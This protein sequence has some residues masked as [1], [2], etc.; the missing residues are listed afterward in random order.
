MLNRLPAWMKTKWAL[1]GLSCAATLIL[2]ALIFLIF[3]K[4]AFATM[5]TNQGQAALEAKDYNKAT[6]KFSVALSLKKNREA[7]YLGYSDALIGNADYSA[8][9]EVLEKGIDRLGGAEELYLSK[10]QVLV[11]SGK[12]GDAVDFLDNIT[13]TYINKKIQASRPAD[14][15]YAPAQGKYSKS[16]EVTIDVR[17]DE[18]VYYTLNGEDPTVNSTVYKEPFT[19]KGSTVITAIAVSEDGLVSPRLTISYEI[20]NANEAIDFSD[21][22]IERMVR[23]ALNRPSGGLYAAQLLSVTDLYNDGINGSIRTLEDLVYLP[24]LQSLQINGELLIE[25]YTPLAG[26]PELTSLSISGCAL[27]DSDLTYISGLSNLNSLHIAD[28]QLTTLDPL[29]TLEN[30]EYLNVSGNA[31]AS[32]STLSQFPKLRYLFIAKNHLRELDGLSELPDLDV[33]DLSN[34]FISDLAPLKNLKA[35]SE[36]HLNGNTPKNIKKLAE[37]PELGILNISDCGLASLSVVNG[38]KNLHTLM[39]YDNEIASLST[40]TLKVREL[41]LA[42]NPL[43]DISPLKKQSKLEVLDL[44]GTSISDISSLAGSG[45]TY[46]NISKTSVTDAS[47]LKK[48]KK[49]E[50]LVCSEQCSTAGLSSKVDITLN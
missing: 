31:I 5:L 7:I 33:L 40:F 38:F 25:D 46:L 19:V 24:S 1:F 21:D 49:L 18:T 10:A 41:H 12:I 16:Q 32:S 35:L 6:D 26:L 37:L 8:A 11:A 50:F 42:N 45:L 28:N 3:L 29:N 14:L 22:K 27:S 48:C 30:L 39:A 23:A 47:S 20:D 36:L 17:K 43:A 34:N 2:G 4:G 9:I 15:S 13:D 44:A